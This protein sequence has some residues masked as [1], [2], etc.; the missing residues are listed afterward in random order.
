VGAE[1]VERT[2]ARVVAATHRPLEQMIAAGT[3]REDLYYRLRVVEIALPPLRE[4]AADIPLLARHLVDR[5][6]ASL[7]L[8]PATLSRDALRAI[9]SHPWPGNVRELENCLI[10]G[11]VLAAGKVLHVEHL[12]IGSPQDNAG[13]TE[14]ATLDQNEAEH[15]QRVLTAVRGNKSRAAE[16]LGVSRPRLNRLLRKHALE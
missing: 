3:F 4:R 7:G 1:R 16:I 11:V 14:H 5:A 15:L 6:C 2:E 13:S 9:E 10:R 12:S 8:T